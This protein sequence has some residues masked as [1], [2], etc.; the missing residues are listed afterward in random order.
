MLRKPNSHLYSAYQRRSDTESKP[1]ADP[2][3]LP[4]VAIPTRTLSRFSARWQP[5]TWGIHNSRQSPSF[6]I[7]AVYSQHL[8]VVDQM[9]TQHFAKGTEE[10][11]KRCT[12]ASRS[13]MLYCICR[14]STLQNPWRWVVGL[15]SGNVAECI[16]DVADGSVAVNGKFDAQRDYLL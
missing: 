14:V 12:I 9:Y 5:C 13:R 15:Y 1:L 3:C 10:V 11:I 6:E 7:Y 4:E 8:P 2:T 16:G